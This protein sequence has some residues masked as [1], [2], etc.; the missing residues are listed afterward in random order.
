MILIL[1]GLGEAGVDQPIPKLGKFFTEYVPRT[2]PI[3]EKKSHRIGPVECL[4]L[5]RIF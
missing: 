1:R 2:M 4:K 3:F 5:C